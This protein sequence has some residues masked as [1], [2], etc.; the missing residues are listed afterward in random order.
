MND[1]KIILLMYGE[2]LD[3]DDELEDRELYIFGR[4]FYKN[5]AGQ[6]TLESLLTNAI[7]RRAISLKDIKLVIDMLPNTSTKKQFYYI[8]L[9]IVLLTIAR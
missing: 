7:N 2:D 5:L 8:P 9:I 4:E 6:T 1:W 3:T